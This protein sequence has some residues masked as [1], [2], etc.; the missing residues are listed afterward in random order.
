VLQTPPT[1]CTTGGSVAADGVGQVT[2]EYDVSQIDFQ[3]I[4]TAEVL[5]TT[6]AQPIAKARCLF[7]LH[8]QRVSLQQVTTG[9][10]VHLD[11]CA[12][13][14]RLG[15]AEPAHKTSVRDGVQLRHAVPHLIADVDVC[16]YI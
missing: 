5:I 1:G 8:L 15:I 2:V 9:H 14:T 13:R 6:N 10:T 7:V 4:Y 11:V 16:C 12:K 3:G